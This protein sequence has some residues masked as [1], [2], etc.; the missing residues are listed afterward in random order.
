MLLRSNINITIGLWVSPNGTIFLFEA[1]A[2]SHPFVML[3]SDE[4]EVTVSMEDLL[5]WKYLHISIMELFHNLSPRDRLFLLT[6]LSPTT[7]E[8]AWV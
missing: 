8:R 5:T 4:Y 1:D 7:Q 6:G 3:Y 2:L